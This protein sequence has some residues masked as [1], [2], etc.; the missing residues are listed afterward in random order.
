MN[1][2]LDGRRFETDMLATI[3]AGGEVPIG[4]V[5]GAMVQ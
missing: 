4:A 2:F 3:V 5:D 1:E